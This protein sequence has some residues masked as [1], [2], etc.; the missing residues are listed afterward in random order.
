MA[1]CWDCSLRLCHFRTK[2]SPSVQ[3]SLTSLTSQKGRGWYIL[4][5]D[6]KRRVG[7]V[8]KKSLEDFAGG[9]AMGE[10]FFCMSSWLTLMG[11]RVSASRC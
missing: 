2:A 10:S 7:I 8:A 9:V 1:S 11:E 3:G 4:R 6:L 5:D